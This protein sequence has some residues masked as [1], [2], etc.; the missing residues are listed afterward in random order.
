MLLRDIR[1]QVFV[2]SQGYSMVAVYTFEGYP[3]R[4]A[5]AG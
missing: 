5:C 4:C 3:V 1:K 2:L